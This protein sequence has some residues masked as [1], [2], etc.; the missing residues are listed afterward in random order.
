MELNWTELNWIGFIVI[1]WV[2]VHKYGNIG[3]KHN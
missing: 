1:V 3:I 2:Y